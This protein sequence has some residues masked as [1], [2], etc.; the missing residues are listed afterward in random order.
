MEPPVEPPGEVTIVGALFGEDS[1][2]SGSET[3]LDSASI[4]LRV[5]SPLR[6]LYSNSL[7]R[8]G[9]AINGFLPFVRREIIAVR[10]I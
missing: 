6:V 3:S 8:A 7:F 10:N 2:Q 5:K 1:V 4:I 9:G